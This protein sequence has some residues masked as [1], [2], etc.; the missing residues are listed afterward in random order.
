MNIFF[1]KYKISC[2]DLAEVVAFYGTQINMN[3]FLYYT[4]KIMCRMKVWGFCRIT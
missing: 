2:D 1:K 4:E 3:Y